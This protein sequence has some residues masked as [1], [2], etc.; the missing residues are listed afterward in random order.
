MSNTPN[1]NLVKPDFSNWADIR[2][3]N[4]NYDKIDTALAKATQAE[5]EAGADTNKLMTPL[6]TKQAILKLSPSLEYKDVT[7]LSA[8]TAGVI[9]WGFALPA[10]VT[11]N[12]LVICRATKDISNMNYDSCISDSSV[13]N[14]TLGKD[15]MSYTYAGLVNNT[16][17]WVKLFVVYI[18]GGKI[19]HSNGV[20][21][22]FTTPAITITE[23][24]N[25]GNEFTA[26]T[27]GWRQG[28]VANFPP[29]SITKNSSFFN[30]YAE[31][32]NVI[33]ISCLVTTNKINFANIKTLKAEVEVNVTNSGFC[34]V[35]LADQN[36]TNITPTMQI[37]NT[38]RQ[39]FSLDV[40]NITTEM[41]VAV[42]AVTTNTA[43]LSTNTLKVYRVW[44]ES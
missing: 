34:R 40:T 2:V 12:A 43:S 27:G 6:A 18:I 3:L 17:Y 26:V 16:Q 39:V 30:I 1:I 14:N 38:S 11:R 41:Y 21:I 7:N 13:T 22:T 37:N 23:F 9:S 25:A 32:T 36:A 35:G 24:Y 15:G 19:Y 20:T 10:D 8:T 33:A 5:A 31:S 28:F 4:E 42:Q 29:A 44:G